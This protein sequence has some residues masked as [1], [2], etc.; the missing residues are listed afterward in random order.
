[1]KYNELKDR[2]F[3]DEY[4]WKQVHGDIFRRPLN[5][6]I[7]S[8]FLGSG[9]QLA[10]LTFSLIIYIIMGDLYTEYDL[11]IYF[12]PWNFSGNIIYWFI[13]FKK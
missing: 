5:L 11:F 6:S 7:L 2:D 1:M 3:G 13:F 4:G 10:V 9:A 8:A 12:L